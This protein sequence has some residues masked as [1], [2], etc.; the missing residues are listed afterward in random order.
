MKRNTFFLFIFIMALGIGLNS[1]TDD[2]VEINE[3]P[4]AITA[5]D[6]SAKYFFTTP[7]YKLFGPDRYP[8][9]RANLI[10]TDRYAGH[11]CFGF[12]G[13]WW[14]D[15]LGYSY[16]GGY[17]DAAWG[18]LEGYFGNINNFMSLTEPGGEFENE[19]MYAVAKIMKSLY[20]Q[21][22]TD[23][24]G[25]IPYSEAGIEGVVTPAFDTQKQIYQGI[26]SDLDDAIATIG[27][28]TATGDGVNDLG[29]NDIF[30]NGDLQK[31][32]KLANTLKLRLAL[33]A[34]GASEAAFASTA[35]DQA[36]TTGEFLEHGE[37]AL[38]PKDLEIS[39]WTSAC[40]GD[41]WHNFGGW[42]SKWT[43]GK[44]VI[45]LLRDNND[46]R[47][48]KYAQPA[49]G[50]E[51]VLKQS[52]LGSDAQPFY[53][54][55]ITFITDMLDDADVNYDIVH[56][57]DTMATIT[58]PENTY[59]IGQPT[60]LNGD[61]YSFNKREFYSMP[62]EIVTNPK[63]SSEIFPELVMT[64]AEAYFLRAEAALRGHGSEDAEAMYQEGIR[65]AMKLWDVSDSEIDNFIANEDIAQ[66][67]GT[68]EENYEKISVQRWLAL[69]TDGFEAWAVVR[70]SGY[71]ADLADGVN[72]EHIYGHGDIGGDYPQRMRYGSNAY[73]QNGTNLQIA[74]GRQGPDV[75]NTKL[76]WADDSN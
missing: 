50:G 66:L 64:A 65:A 30:F 28:A 23:V 73:N 76:W 31:W 58:I 46:P 13:C 22:F 36:L 40:Y 2:F 26:I 17:T 67:N 60:R 74:I 38:Q 14:S 39:Q 56:S 37:D 63:G 34:Y 69:Y 41:I 75:Q 48:S 5:E 44:P 15:E 42:G 52:S 61:F 33:R 4:T 54:E 62:A 21:M 6:A 57:G 47:L 8:Y 53:S 7:Q 71:P 68:F 20:Y 29:E 49:P 19:K 1:C 10:H 72:N 27:D 11:F 55:Y 16:S 3:N 32:K 51:V 70:K 9:W 25:E 45:D 24:F 43:V 12:Y 35:V 59:Y 18:Y